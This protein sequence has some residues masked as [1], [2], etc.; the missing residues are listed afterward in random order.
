MLHLYFF[1]KE[2]TN[3][4]FATVVI[5][6]CRIYAWHDIWYLS[7]NIVVLRL[8][9]RCQ[10]GWYCFSRVQK[11]LGDTRKTDTYED[12]KFINLDNQI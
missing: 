7:E 10:I 9:L 1:L 8:L 2:V 4:I 6:I 3:S 5:D 12:M 11:L